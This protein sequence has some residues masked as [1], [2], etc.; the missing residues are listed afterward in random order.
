LAIKIKI[1][2][3][4]S[5][6]LTL[7]EKTM[8]YYIDVLKKYADFKGR[9]RRQEYWM[10]S[11]FHAMIIIALVIF[12]SVTQTEALLY[13]LVAYILATTLPSLAV[14]VRRNHDSGKSGWFV[15]VP[16][17]NLYLLFIDSEPNTN[18]YGPNPKNPEDE[19]SQIGRSQA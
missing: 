14:R 8:K 10:F 19:I 16:Y 2:L 11:L 1:V 15:L 3:W 12:Y 5:I 17:Y 9:A 7:K 13:V 4:F 6:I 18:Q